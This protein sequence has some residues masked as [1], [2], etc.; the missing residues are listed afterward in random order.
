M[1]GFFAQIPF[2][3]NKFFNKKKFINSSKY[4]SHRGPDDKRFLFSNSINLSFYR[5]SIIDQSSKANQPMV[6]FSKELIIVFNGEIYNAE[7]LKI[8]LKGY[9][10]KSDSDTEILLNMYHK[11]GKECLKYLEG[12]FS[13]LI[14]NK[15]DYSCFIARDRFGIKPLYIKKDNH[16]FLVSSEIKPIL[17]FSSENNFNKKAFADFLFRQKMD[18]HEVSF[19]KGIKSIQKS[20]FAII[21]KDKI[22]K[23][24]YWSIIAKN[25]TESK[26]FEKDYLN[27][28]KNSIKSHLISDRKIGLLFSGGT[29][30]A[31][32]ASIMKKN[33]LEKFTN[34]TYDFEDN[35]IGDGKISKKISKNLKIK[36]KLKLIKPKDVINDFDQMCL[37]LESPFTSI[38]LFGHHN[39]LKEMKKDNVA[40]ALEGTGGDEILGGY[41]YNLIHFYLDQ[42]KTKKDINKFINLLLK[43]NAR[44]FYN[45]INT[46]KDQFSMLKNCEPFLNKEYFNNR[47]LSQK[48]IKKQNNKKNN[49]KINFLQKSQLVDIDYINLTRSLKYSDRLSMSCGIENR[50]PFLDTDLSAFCFNLRNDYKIKDGIERYISKKATGKMIKKEIFSKEKK[51]ITDPQTKWLKTHLKEFILDNINSRDFKEYE[52]L[53]TKK[54]IRHFDK[55]IKDDY[56]SSFDTFMNFS[57][58]M[59]YKNF[60]NKFNVTFKV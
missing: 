56:T 29:D 34:Y 30:S 28:L 59:F 7:K 49:N 21:K 3:S 16:Q 36:N 54:F 32:L 6:S 9:N 1:C 5:L 11:Y 37:R 50:V 40:V 31:V 48:I 43:R 24:K 60:K 12:M 13:F 55:F 46:I 22:Y 25:N 42:I 20:T 17:N 23:F 44:K 14:F 19:F 51:A 15:N 41:E 52:I 27:L 38:R 8:K 35:N 53:D 58:F 18:H 47:F 33:Y 26:N 10:F 2:K 39:C 57:T 45:Y 4:I